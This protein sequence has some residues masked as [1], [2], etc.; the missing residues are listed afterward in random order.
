MWANRKTRQAYIYIDIQH[1]IFGLMAG[2]FPQNSIFMRCRHK[3]GWVGAH[4]QKLVQM[5][6]VGYTSTGGAQNNTKIYI[7]GSVGQY[8]VT[9]VHGNKIRLTLG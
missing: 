8:L 4:G 5:G 3:S 2:K 7:N 9:H 1:M 6:A